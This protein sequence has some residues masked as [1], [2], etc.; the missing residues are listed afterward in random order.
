MVW[1]ERHLGI[2]TLYKKIKYKIDSITDIINIIDEQIRIEYVDTM[3]AK[4]KAENLITNY[5]DKVKK[6][7]R[8]L[9]GV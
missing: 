8:I 6:Q 5:Q 9:P 2:F 7:E 3:I 1:P 4:R